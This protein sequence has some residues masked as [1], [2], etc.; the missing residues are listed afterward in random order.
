MIQA[1]NSGKGVHVF[2]ENG[3][4]LEFVEELTAIIRGCREHLA[5]EYGD[6]F[7]DRV[8]EYSGRMAY[9]A[10]DE[11]KE[12]ASK[13]FVDWLERSKGFVDWLERS[14]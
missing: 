10:N 12:K 14:D 4:M 11:E 7:A 13:A 3:E 1:I 6:A 2:I 9:A 5:K 8:I